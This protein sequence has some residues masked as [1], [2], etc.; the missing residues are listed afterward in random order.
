MPDHILE[1]SH[2]LRAE[3]FESEQELLDTLAQ[4]GQS[5]DAMCLGCSDS[6]VVSA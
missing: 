4:T 1:R 3:F 5:P 2:A 6:R